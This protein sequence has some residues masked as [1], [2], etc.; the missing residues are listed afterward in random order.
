MAMT[1]CF[2]DPKARPWIL[3]LATK[4]SMPVLS[5]LSTLFR[6]KLSN[7]IVI[8]RHIYLRIIG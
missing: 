6:E 4:E 2:D 5:V 8:D 7:D 3:F 1:G